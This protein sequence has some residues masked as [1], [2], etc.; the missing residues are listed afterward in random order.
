MYFLRYLLHLGA[1][2]LV[3]KKEVWLHEHCLILF[4]MI[5]LMPTVDSHSL[6]N[7]VQL[8]PFAFDFS[9]FKTNKINFILILEF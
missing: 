7:P 6:Y 5:Q 9:I 3:S 4:T 8:S 1:G 2:S